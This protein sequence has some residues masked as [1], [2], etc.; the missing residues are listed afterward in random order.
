M[1]P[2]QR[3]SSHVTSSHA[4]AR[5]CFAAWPL[6]SHLGSGASMLWAKM[7]SLPL[8]LPL[9]LPLSET[10]DKMLV[11]WQNLF[12]T[13]ADMHAPIRSKRVRNK[14][15]PWLTSEIRKLIVSRDKLKRLAIISRNPDHWTE[16]KTATN[17]V[18][19]KTSEF[20]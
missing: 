15:S 16:F 14:K 4:T 7:A 17:L 10:P 3:K 2:A 20:W 9:P 5:V 11:I 13:V 1:F 12:T 6:P 8:P 19:T 18:N